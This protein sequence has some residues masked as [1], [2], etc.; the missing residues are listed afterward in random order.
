M[1]TRRDNLL[2]WWY[3]AFMFPTTRRCH[4][5]AD[6]SPHTAHLT[7]VGRLRFTTPD[8]WAIGT[9]AF[10]GAVGGVLVGLWYR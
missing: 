2:P 4:G 10:V 9:A 3:R 6:P 5:C 1:R 7:L 8:W